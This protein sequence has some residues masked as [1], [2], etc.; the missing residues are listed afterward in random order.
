MICKTMLRDYPPDNKI[1]GMEM[2]DS[3]LD[4]YLWGKSMRV[5]KGKV[6]KSEKLLPVIDSAMN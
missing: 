5:P 4:S 1:L 2:E 6:T 3:V